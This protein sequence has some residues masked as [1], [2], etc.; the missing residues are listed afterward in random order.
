LRDRRRNAKR[1][2]CSALQ[3]I[4]LLANEKEGIVYKSV[5]TIFKRFQFLKETGH[6]LFSSCSKESFMALFLEE[7]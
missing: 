5:R 3:S 7:L 2:A 4:S 6:T 1:D